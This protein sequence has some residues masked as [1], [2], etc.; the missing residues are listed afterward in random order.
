M[1]QTLTSVL[2]AVAVYALLPVMALYIRL[3]K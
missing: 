3:R 1:G 2:A